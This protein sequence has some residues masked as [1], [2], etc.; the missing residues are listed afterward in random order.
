MW[1]YQLEARHMSGFTVFPT[2]HGIL[3]FCFHILKTRLMKDSALR[4][5]ADKTFQNI[6]NPLKGNGVY[7]EIMKAVQEAYLMGKLG[8]QLLM[9]PI[10]ENAEQPGSFQHETI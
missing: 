2:W 5:L 4:N 10:A 1:I 3:I 7:A 6:A 9:Q 8:K